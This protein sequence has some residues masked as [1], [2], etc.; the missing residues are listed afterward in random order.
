MTDTKKTVRLLS[1][2]EGQENHETDSELFNL[3]VFYYFSMFS[4]LFLFHCVLWSVLCH[5]CPHSH[6]YYVYK[7]LISEHVQISYMS[8]IYS[9]PCGSEATSEAQNQNISP[10]PDPLDNDLADI[11]KTVITKLKT[12]DAS[13]STQKKRC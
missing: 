3:S 1:R 6:V 7:C 5:Y 11:I 12:N 8:S 9:K 10:E 13:H 2:I 4:V